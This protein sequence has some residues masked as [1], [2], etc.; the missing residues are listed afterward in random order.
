MQEIDAKLEALNEEAKTVRAQYNASAETY[1]NANNNLPAGD[2]SVRAIYETT[3]QYRTQLLALQKK[4]YD[5]LN[6]RNN[7]V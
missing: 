2:P 7:I 6:E 3:Q 5:L 1:E 4:G